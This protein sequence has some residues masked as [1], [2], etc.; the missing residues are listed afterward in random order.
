MQMVACNLLQFCSYLE[1]LFMGQL[2][3]EQLVDFPT[4]SDS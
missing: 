4:I 2:L 3:N 1:S